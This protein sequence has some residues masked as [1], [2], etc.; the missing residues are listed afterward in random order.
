M[1]TSA[2]VRSRTALAGLCLAFAVAYGAGAPLSGNQNT[3][4]LHAAAHAGWGTVAADWS[5]HSPDPFPVF[6]TLVQPMLAGRPGVWLT[7]TH[8]FLVAL[9]AYALAAIAAATFGWTSIAVAPPLLIAA[10]FA[11]HSRL[12]ASASMRAAGVDARAILVDGVAN[13]YVLGPVLQPS[14][15]GVLIIAAIALFLHDRP[16]LAIVSAV[17]A[18]IGHTTYLLSAALFTL[19]CGGVLVGR[20]RWRDAAGIAALSFVLA[21]PVVAYAALTFAPTDAATFDR[22]AHLLADDRIAI[23]ARVATWFGAAT[24]VKAGVVGAALWVVRRRPI[25]PFLWPA[26]VVA[27]VSTAVLAASPNPV[28]ALQFP[29]RVSVWLVPIAATLLAAHWCQTG[30]RR[31]ADISAGATRTPAARRSWTACAIAI[32]G[33]VAYGAVGS[34]VEARRVSRTPEAPLRDRVAA[35]VSAGEIYLVP[36]DMEDFRLRTRAAI[37]VDAK[38]HPYKDV[39]V[40]AWKDRLDHARAFYAERGPARCEELGAIAR[41]YAATRV[42]VPAGDPV[43][44]RGTL[45]TYADAAFAIYAIE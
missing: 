18:A 26:F 24:I 17:A 6:T 38:T 31:L 13:Q 30:V 8:L 28:L 21:L 20:G 36:P 37:V 45:R 4:L 10:V 16:W 9:Y 34:A 15:S 5:A 19:S 11:A 40:L 33:L 27:L 3:Y 23:H 22:A 7:I 25:F 32:A 41:R 29:W 2:P 12:L 1:T 35:G 14:M 39:D 42:V 44:C 43:T